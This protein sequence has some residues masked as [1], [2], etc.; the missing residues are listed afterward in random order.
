MNTISRLDFRGLGAL[1]DQMNRMFEDTLARHRA[2][3]SDLAVWAPAADIYET[4]QELVIKA[5]LPD[6]NEKDIDIRFENGTL[7][8]RGERQ[9][10]KDASEDS[11]LRVERPY[12]AFTRSFSLPNTINAEAIR[13]EYQSG[14]LSVHMAKREESRARQIKIGVSS[15]GEAFERVRTP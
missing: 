14:V 3:E 7:T 13:A 5:D 12:G 11:Y 10:T 6:I 1:Q 2:G 8:I 4:E 15:N 9:L